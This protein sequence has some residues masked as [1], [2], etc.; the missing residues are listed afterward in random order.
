[1]TMR[2]KHPKLGLWRSEASL[3]QEKVRPKLWRAE[4]RY[5]DPA[6]HRVRVITAEGET[7]SGAEEAL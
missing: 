2:G 4:V 7:K 1:M 3:K 6:T 5:H